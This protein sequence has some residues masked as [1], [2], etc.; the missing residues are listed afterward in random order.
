MLNIKSFF[1]LI[2]FNF[3]HL[4][5]FFAFVFSTIFAIVSPDSFLEYLFFF[6]CLSVGSLSYAWFYLWT[7][8]KMLQIKFLRNDLRKVLEIVLETLGE[9]K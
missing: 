2:A 6:L 7:F 1:F 4:I 3:I 8:S 5:L 9:V